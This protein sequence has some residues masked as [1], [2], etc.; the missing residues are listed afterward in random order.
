[1]LGSGAR[2]DALGDLF[3]EHQGQRSPPRRPLASQP[4]QQQR[5]ADIVGQIGDDMGAVAGLGALVDAHRVAFDDL[6]ALRI[7]LLELGQ[8]RPTAA[9]ALDRDDVRSGVEQRPSQSAG[10]WPDLID[11]LAVQRSR[12]GG[13]PRQQL[14]VE[15]EILAER[16]ASLETVASDDVT[17]R[18]GRAL[19]SVGDR[20]TPHSAA[21]RIAA[22][23]ARGSAWSCPAMSNAVPWSGAVRMIGRPSVTLTPSSKCSAFN[24]IRAWS[25][26]MHK[27]QS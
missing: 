25:W 22:A 5:R 8:G 13:D 11:S 15:N 23:M 9:I 26:Y 3:L 16:L 2:D 6:E 1:M 18:L 20:W 27:A 24:G 21:S 17:Q 7:F 10:A 4:A 14:P 12:N 19:H